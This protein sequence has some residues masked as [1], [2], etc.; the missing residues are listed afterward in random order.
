MRRQGYRDED[1]EDL[2][3]AEA[4]SRA[5]LVVTLVGHPREV[6]ELPLGPREYAVAGQLVGDPKGACWPISPAEDDKCLRPVFIRLALFRAE[7]GRPASAAEAL[8]LAGWDAQ[9][10]IEDTSRDRERAYK[11]WQESATKKAGGELPGRYGQ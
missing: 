9:K 8:E 6:I 7:S 5:Y 3:W 10:A 4:W 1:C 11:L 2:T